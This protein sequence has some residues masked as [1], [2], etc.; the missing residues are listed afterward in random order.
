MICLSGKPLLSSV[1]QRKHPRAWLNSEDKRRVRSCC[2]RTAWTSPASAS[3]RKSSVTP[4]ALAC[5]A[6]FDVRPPV[7]RGGVLALMNSFDQVPHRWTTC[8]V[9]RQREPAAACRFLA[10]TR[11]AAMACAGLP[12]GRPGSKRIRRAR[13]RPEQASPS[14]TR[15]CLLV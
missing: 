2:M 15:R 3:C 6:R 12:T 1:F 10:R 14:V 11:F 7:N 4:E 9:R 13:R 8:L 5:S